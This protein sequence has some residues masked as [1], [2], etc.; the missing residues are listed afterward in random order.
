MITRK[1]IPAAI[2]FVAGDGSEHTSLEAAQE[3]D[4]IVVLSDE[5]ALAAQKEPTISI[6]LPLIVNAVLKRRNNVMDILTTTP[7]SIVKARLLHG[8]KKVRTKRRHVAP[9]A[10]LPV[11]M[12]AVNG[13]VATTTAA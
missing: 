11:V 9:Q 4:L 13:E 8:G 5:L 10:E 3:Q 1:T 12:A 2:M 7:K 6:V